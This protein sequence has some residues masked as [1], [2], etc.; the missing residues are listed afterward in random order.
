V[1]IDELYRTLKPSLISLAY[2]MLG[3]ITDAEDI[4]QV[5]FMALSEAKEDEIRSAKSFLYRVVT[6]KCIDLLRSSARQREMYVGPWLPEPVI[7]DHYVQDEPLDYYVEKES[8]STAYLLLMHQL[9]W[10][11]RVVF[12]LRE[13][14]QYDY[15]EIAK[16]V[17]KST[18][19]CRQIFRRAKNAMGDF[20]AQDS[21]SKEKEKDLV[22]KFVT[23]LETGNIK[24]LLN[25][26]SSDAALL[27]DG[28]G[29][30]RAPLRV[31]RGSDRITKFIEGIMSYAP[32]V[33]TAKFCELN[34]LPGIIFYVDGSPIV[35]FSFQFKDDHISDVYMLVEPGKLAALNLFEQ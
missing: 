11:E 14:L 31:L 6:N 16:I 13:V 28:G 9:N 25:I 23:A 7:T 20:S 1:N 24:I 2:R 17:D 8:I 18:A 34:G 12:L 4:V 15:E 29:K 30:V 33:Y 19:N 35:A 32:T 5:A 27:A 26:L 21:T 10:V 3:R 22:E